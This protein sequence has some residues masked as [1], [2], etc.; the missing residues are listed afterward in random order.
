MTK[1][2]IN[3]GATANDKQGDSLRAAFQK[4]NANFTELYEAIGL[5]DTGQDTSLTFVGSTIS[6]DD[7]S[8]ITI[9]RAVTVSSNLSVGG[10][11]LPQT[12]NGGDLGSASMPWKSLY[13]SNSTVYLGGVPLSL[14]TGTNTLKV[15]NVPISQNITYTDIPNAP[16]DISDLTDTTGL[17]SSGTGD[18]T[19]SGI[20]IIGAGTASGD[21]NG[22]STLELVPDNDLYAGNQ[23]LIIDPTAPSHIHIRAG[24][25]Q[26]NS[27][28]QLYLG[29]ENSHV[30]I[31]AGIDPPVIVRSNS[32]QWTFETGGG[33]TLPGAEDDST[34]VV[35]F[36]GGAA[37][38]HKVTLHS[39]WTLKIKARAS[40]ANQGN[41]WLE[42]GQNTKIKVKGNGS[43]IDIVA[44]DGT[45]SATW[46]FAKTGTLTFPATLDGQLFLSGSEI[47]GVD[48]NSVALSSNTSVVINTYNPSPHT[49]AF[50]N[51]GS[52]TFPDST[53]QTT[54]FTGTGY[55]TF[56]DAAVR[57]TSDYQYTFN[58]DGYFT[59]ST[60]SESTNYFFV[61]NNTTN[62]NI[63]A[64]W[65]VVG[66][67]C[68]TTVS[69]TQYPVPGYPNV[70]KVTL[71]AAA[72]S[73]SGFY[74]VVVSDPNRLKVQLQPNPGTGDK[75]T[76][77]TTGITFPDASVQT[78]AW[79]GT[80]TVNDSGLTI[81]GGTGTI[82][83]GPSGA[84]QVGDKKGGVYHASSTS[85]NGL[86]T[87]G[88]NGSGIMSAAVE[89]SVFIGTSMPSNNGGVTT[90]YPGW[91]VVQNGGKFG[92]DVDT[93][94]NV[95]LGKGVFEKFQTKQDATG[96]VEHDCINGHIFYHTSPDANWTANF[97]NLNIGAGYA[98]SVS[99]VIAQ[100]GTGYYPDAVQIGG[101]GQTINWQGNATPT[102]STN[103]TDVVT[104][105]ILN[106]SGTYVVLGQ[107]TGF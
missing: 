97:T 30:M 1:Q 26:D 57:G 68:N 76:F 43:T 36:F 51:D 27:S 78:T 49:W 15:N 38:N 17:L 83:Q 4:V 80:L 98:T 82:Y 77:A 53:V 103:R 35:D 86:F 65:T 13:V 94:G 39:D 7:S 61:A 60:S 2:I 101:V 9:D 40:A 92:A 6:T 31:G 29:G 72:S 96:T 25:T 75:Y 91:L 73:T 10:D 33:L 105:S 64:G 5:S 37:D 24:G 74:P 20:K 8:S 44:S 66:A 70:I 50:A 93:L 79:T 42:A 63:T 16:T 41:L 3:V 59:S 81:N 45:T 21:G 100:G 58:T 102:P 71:T 62:Q 54:A 19:F 99:I 52:I 107:I 104:F 85:S 88:M 22:Y 14:E 11:I 56:D 47:A 89:G 32:H 46:T 67:N 87:F 95:I 90:A 69:S 12:A 55:L 106:N 23:Y 28:A 34:P 48:N 18:V 84:L